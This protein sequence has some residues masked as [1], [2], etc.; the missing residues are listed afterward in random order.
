M[1]WRIIHKAVTASTNADAHHGKP[2]DVF[3]AD[4]QT[5]GRGRLDHVATSSQPI[6]RPLAADASTTC[7]SRARGRTS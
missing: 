1:K 7:G 6:S 3:T 5:A 2:G 4:F